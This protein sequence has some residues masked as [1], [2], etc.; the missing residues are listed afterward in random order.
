MNR[1]SGSPGFRSSRLGMRV[2]TANARPRFEGDG[3]A[4]HFER[5]RS[6]LQDAH[7]IQ[8]FA[9]AAQGTISFFNA[10]EEM[11]AF[12]LQRFLLLHK[13][14]IAISIVIGVMKLREGVMRRVPTMVISRIFL[15]S[16]QLL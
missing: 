3:R 13:R 12:H 9:S 8:S 15:G 4:V 10:V 6:G 14:D 2:A 1:S 16:S 11:L 5:R 7:Q